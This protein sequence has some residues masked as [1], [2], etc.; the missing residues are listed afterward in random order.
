MFFVLDLN[1]YEMGDRG[2]AINLIKIVYAYQ[3]IFFKNLFI[4]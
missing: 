2:N 3:S 1:F 4:L